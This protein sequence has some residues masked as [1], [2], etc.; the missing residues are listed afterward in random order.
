VFARH[1]R[2]AAWLLVPLLAWVLFAA[3]LNFA[4]WRLNPGA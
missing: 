1:D 2:V 3:A 4:I